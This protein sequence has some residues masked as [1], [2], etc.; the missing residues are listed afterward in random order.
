MV[1]RTPQTPNPKSSILA[2]IRLLLPL[3]LV[4]SAQAATG[5]R[6]TYQ[7]EQMKKWCEQLKQEIA[8]FDWR[9]DPCPEGVAFKVGGQSVQGRPLVYADFGDPNAKN[10]TLILSAVHGDEITPV[11][12][13]LQTIHWL[14]LHARELH[15]TRVIVAPLVNPDGFFAR[16]RKRVNSHGVDVN[17]NFST[18]DWNAHALASWKNKFRSDPRRFPGPRPRSEPETLFQEDLIHQ[19]RPQKVLSIHAPLNFMDYDGPT[20]MSLAQ[21][22]SEYVRVCLKLRSR[23]RAITS[24]YFPGSLG[25]FA[26]HERGIPTLTLELPS[27][28]PRRAERYWKLFSRGIHT[29]IEFQ[30]PSTA[31]RALGGM[32]SR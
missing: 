4:I 10:T 8:G 22:P 19:F 29:M 31:S 17:R 20:A 7:P 12:V 30:V 3:M 11:Y 9:I 15:E 23:L 2:M 18:R 25:N 1:D 6:D 27:A 32:A 28:D 16:P 14:K 21:F 5:I 24:G 13:G 26:G